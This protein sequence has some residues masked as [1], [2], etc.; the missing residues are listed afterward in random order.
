MVAPP[1]LHGIGDSQALDKGKGLNRGLLNIMSVHVQ[2]CLY[3]MNPIPGSMIPAVYSRKEF[4]MKLELMK[5]L[6][7]QFIFRH[8]LHK[9]DQTI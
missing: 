1:V 2:D 3:L 6:V 5:N 9:K 8:L 7:T 4:M